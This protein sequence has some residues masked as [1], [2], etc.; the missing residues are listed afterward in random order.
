MMQLIINKKSPLFLLFVLIIFITLFISCNTK[1]SNTPMPKIIINSDLLKIDN[2]IKNGLFHETKI[3]IKKLLIDSTTTD[4]IKIQLRFKKDLMDRINIDFCKDE[5]YIRKNL[6]KYYPNLTDEILNQWEISNALEVRIIDG[7]KKYFYNAIP[8][9]FRIDKNAKKLKEKLDGISKDDLKFFCKEHTSKIIEKYKTQ[10]KNLLNPINMKVKYNLTVDADVVP[11]GELIRCWLPF[12]REDKKRQ[13][14]IKLLNTNIKNY[15]IAPEHY[16]QRSIYMEKSAENGVPT[17]FEIEF[18]YTSRAEYH[19]LSNIEIKEYDTK[20][21]FYK[22]YTSE[23]MPHIVFSERIKKITDKL[24]IDINTPYEKVRKIYEWIDENIPWASALEYSTFWNIP[25]YVLD[26]KHGDCGMQSLLF[27]TM[28]RYAGI[29]AKWQSGW[30]MHPNNKNLH[31]W[32]EVYYP[33]IG[34]VP[35]D[36]SF[37]L[38]K[39]ED[40][41]VKYFYTSGIDAYRLIVNDD[42]SSEFYPLKI[43]PRSETVDFQ[44]G[45]VE[46]RG[47]NIYFD[48]WDYHMEIIYE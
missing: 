44:R 5:E 15:I 36:Q 45:E 19:N 11:A 42:I 20:S 37:S 25:E 21:E 43:F 30:M 27:I 7:E 8:N 10:N 40:N 13:Q 34:W 17:K 48:K 28:A 23:N 3:L 18:S 9:L 26:N 33:S 1:E 6:A 14:N 32:A 47:G 4:E 39:I 16:Q 12:P 2:N 41:D 22:K 46:W 29:P 24:L 31:D 38:Q 35:V